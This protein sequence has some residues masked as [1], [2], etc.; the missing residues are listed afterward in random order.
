MFAKTQKSVSM[1][2]GVALIAAATFAAPALAG[3]ATLS[4]NEHAAQSAIAGT[5]ES[6]PASTDASPA[7]LA[8]NESLAQR[9]I[10][11][12]SAPGSL[13]AD[14]AGAVTLMQNEIAAQRAIVDATAFEG[15]VRHG[16]H[17]T[18]SV[19]SMRSPAAH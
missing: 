17:A 13:R 15:S 19:V 3:E 18:T 12:V 7:T 8:R 11:E 5:R 2:L 16:S 14:T 6:A 1:I 9:A 4:Q 10:V